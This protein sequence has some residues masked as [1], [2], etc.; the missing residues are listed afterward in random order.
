MEHT[1]TVVSGANRLK[2]YNIDVHYHETCVRVFDYKIRN[3]SGIEY[4]I[5]SHKHSGNETFPLQNTYRVC[6]KV[7]TATIHEYSIQK[8]SCISL[9]RPVLAHG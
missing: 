2:S 1:A 9:S 7:T 8:A 4:P 3:A 6:E 5:H